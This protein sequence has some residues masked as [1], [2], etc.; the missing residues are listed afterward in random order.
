MNEKINKKSLSVA[1]FVV[2]A[3]FFVTLLIDTYWLPDASGNTSA[4][5][6]TILAF[7]GA[8]QTTALAVAM[9]EFIAKKAFA[10]EI[11]KLAN[12]SANVA[13]TGIASVYDNYLDMDWNSI[14]G[15]TKT[16]TIAVSYA[17]TWRENNRVKLKALAT[18]PDAVKVFL[19]NYKSEAILSELAVRFN[20][21]PDA[22]KTKIS[23]SSDSFRELGATVYLYNSC[24]QTS[25]YLADNEAI[26]AVF[27][28]K[29]EKSVVPTFHVTRQGSLYKFIEEELESIRA[30]S[31]EE[32]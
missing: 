23:E 11:L 4:W 16:L 1:L 13:N 28:H 17:N 14:F 5:K 25:Y 26:M 24:F 2:L 9:W 29:K 15:R 22:V 18:V 27:N 19:P 20:M 7:I 31:Q 3:L 6:S 32:R 30:N 10:K 12:I 21:R 8:V